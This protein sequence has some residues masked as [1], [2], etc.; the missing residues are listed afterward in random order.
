MV[1]SHIFIP[2]DKRF[3]VSGK[4]GCYVKLIESTHKVRI[5][6]PGRD[7]T[8]TRVYIVGEAANVK[9]AR[10]HVLSLVR[11][12][13][14][15][16]THPGF[17]KYQMDFPRDKVGFLIGQRGSKIKNLQADTKCQILVPNSEERQLT[18]V[19]PSEGVAHARTI[20]ERIL[21][22]PEE[23]ISNQHNNRENVQPEYNAFD[24]CADEEDLGNDLNDYAYSRDDDT[25][26]FA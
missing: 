6:I 19:G 2:V 21:N 13:F 8:Q 15:T 18:I 22:P 11:Y 16:L 3:R 23:K 14:S 12:A 24:P 26:N 20:I 25:F 17:I 4:G 1:D 7:S 10:V 5:R 9:K